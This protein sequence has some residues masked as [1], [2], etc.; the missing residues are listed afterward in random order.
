[1]IGAKINV[2]QNVGMTKCNPE[3]KGIFAKIL[4]M[5][6]LNEKVNTLSVSGEW[7]RYS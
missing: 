1:M 7:D 3:K 2:A 6:R 4:W 5:L